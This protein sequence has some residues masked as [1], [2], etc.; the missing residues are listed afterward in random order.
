MIACSILSALSLV[1]QDTISRTA[2]VQ[3]GGV[4][5]ISHTGSVIEF[6]AY[7]FDP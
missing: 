3:L 7:D 6:P 2:Q 1:R 4:V 5:A